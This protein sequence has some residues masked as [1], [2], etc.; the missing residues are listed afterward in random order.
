MYS[1][2]VT[3]EDSHSV[4]D[5]CYQFDVCQAGEC[6]CVSLLLSAVLVSFISYESIFTFITLVFYVYKYVLCS[7]AVYLLLFPSHVSFI[8]CS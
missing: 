8:I 1:L 3:N 7:V 5:L 4:I 2:Q 6:A